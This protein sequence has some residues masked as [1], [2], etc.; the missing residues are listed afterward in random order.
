LSRNINLTSRNLIQLRAEVFNIFN[1]PNF[2]VP[3]R[4]FD[5]PTFG[6]LDSANAYGN[7][8]ARQLQLGIR[9]SF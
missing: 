4:V 5:S 8:P 3:D 9:Y 1:H 2:D 7:R 6:S